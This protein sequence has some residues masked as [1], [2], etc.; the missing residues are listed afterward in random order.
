[1]STSPH[2]ATERLILALGYGGLLPFAGLALL[3]WL[4]DA[5]LV[6][7]VALAL[8]GYG[9]AIV[10]FLGGIH[11]GVGLRYAATHIEGHRFHLVWGV[12]PALLAW[13]ALLMPAYAGLPA[14]AGVLALCYLVDRRTWADAGLAHWLPLR[15][16]LTVVAALSCLLGAAAT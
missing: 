5:E 8:Q 7:F 3:M 10:S 9:A 16:R 12:V 6:P 14:L 4:V 15:F 1:M 2:A 13:V 11:W